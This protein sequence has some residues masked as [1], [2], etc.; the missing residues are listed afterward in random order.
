MA[1]AQEAPALAA[2]SDVVLCGVGKINAAAATAFAI[3][4][5]R[6]DMIINFGTAGSLGVAPA[7]YPVSRFVQRDMRCEALGV[8]AGCTPFEDTGSMIWNGLDG[9]ICSTGD[10]FVSAADH[11]IKADVVDMEAYA[12]AK[13]CQMRG[14]E[15]RCWKYVTDQANSDAAADWQANCEAGQT[16]YLGILTALGI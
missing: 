7:L 11:D 16:Q 8:P 12:I 5:H 9:A 14:V 1:L 6:P 2:R 10:N 13:V 3:A 4:E 15:F